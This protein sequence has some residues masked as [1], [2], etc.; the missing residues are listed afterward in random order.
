MLSAMIRDKG[1]YVKNFKM[2]LFM[3]LSSVG[4]S[5]RRWSLKRT[6]MVYVVEK[7]ERRHGGGGERKK[8]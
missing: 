5:R 4:I 2:S 8:A 3:A 6:L 7:H 1:S